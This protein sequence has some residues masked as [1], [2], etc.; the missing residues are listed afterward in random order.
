ME[1][2]V[3]EQLVHASNEMRVAMDDFLAKRRKIIHPKR[4]RYS[5][6]LLILLIPFCGIMTWQMAE[7]KNAPLDV[8][9]IYVLIT[10]GKQLD[11]LERGDYQEFPELQ[12]ALQEVRTKNVQVQELSK[13][14]KKSMV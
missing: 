7:F 9:C 6:H 8:F 10:C 12:Q 14:L 5:L 2:T 1:K 13:E 4:L 11:A 3:Q